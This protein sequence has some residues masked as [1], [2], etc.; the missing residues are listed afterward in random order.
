M[1]LGRNSNPPKTGSTLTVKIPG[2]DTRGGAGDIRPPPPEIS[3]Q[4]MF[5]IC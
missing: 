1:N 5:P 3:R 2:A 4:K